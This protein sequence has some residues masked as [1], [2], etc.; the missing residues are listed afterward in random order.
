MVVVRRGRRER[1]L[2]PEDPRLGCFGG[3][4]AKFKSRRRECARAE[5]KESK[6]TALFRVEH[7]F[8]LLLLWV[9]FGCVVVGGWLVIGY[10]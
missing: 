4:P 9:V 10:R 2:F 1:F 6:H 5:S 7:S 8:M 3:S